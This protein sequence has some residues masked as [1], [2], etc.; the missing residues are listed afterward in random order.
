V[1]I[2]SAGVLYAWGQN[3][4]GQ[5]GI[6]STTTVSVPTAVATTATP[7]TTVSSGQGATHTFGITS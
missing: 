3:T 2:T 1:A 7:I 6:G 4:A 5:L